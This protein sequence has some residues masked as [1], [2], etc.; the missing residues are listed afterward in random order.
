MNGQ[1]HKCLQTTRDSIQQSRPQSITH[2][3]STHRGKQSTAAAEVLAVQGSQKSRACSN[4]ERSSTALADG[5]SQQISLLN[6]DE[7]SHMSIATEHACADLSRSSMAAQQSAALDKPLSRALT[8]EGGQQT[9][10]NAEVDRS[11]TVL[12]KD[13][14]TNSIRDKYDKVCQ[15]FNNI[16]ESIQQH[17]KESNFFETRQQFNS[18]DEGKF[19]ESCA[20]EKILDITDI[21]V[22]ERVLEQ[23]TMEEHLEPVR[24]LPKSKYEC[25][26]LPKFVGGGEVHDS[27]THSHAQKH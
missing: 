25:E 18:S 9:R 22:S 23:S 15:Q 12:T 20:E 10:D 1:S 4:L 6:L 17:W 27:L 7:R 2:Q 21:T 26:V 16:E 8:E 13:G 14:K 3:Q 19:S 11:S 5:Q 24:S